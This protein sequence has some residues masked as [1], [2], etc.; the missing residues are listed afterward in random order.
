MARTFGEL[1]DVNVE[2][3]GDKYLIMYDGTQQK[4]VA[5]NPD[6]VLVNAVQGSRIPRT[7][8]NL[9]IS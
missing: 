5:I 7:L 6:D 1:L 8:L 9:K 4:Y 2:N 3:A